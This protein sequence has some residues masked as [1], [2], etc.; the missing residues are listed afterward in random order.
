MTGY[1]DP[2]ILRCPTCGK[3]CY[4]TRKTARQ[5][6]RRKHPGHHLSAYR[7]GKFWHLGHLPDDITRGEVDRSVLKPRKARK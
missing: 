7:C 6:A 2:G 3:W 5:A 1:R 4:L